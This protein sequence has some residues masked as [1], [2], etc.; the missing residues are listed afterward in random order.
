MREVEMK[1]RAAVPERISGIFSSRLGKAHPVHKADHYFRRPGESIQALRMRTNGGR[2][3]FT[4]KRTVSINGRE[5]NAEYEFHGLPGDEEAA[6][7]F[8]HALGYE[9]FFVKKKDGWEWNDGDAHIELLSV[10][11][12]GWFLEIEVLLPFDSSVED[13]EAARRHIEALMNEAG[14]GESD[15]ETR[16]YREMITGRK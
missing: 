13:G 8:F 4:T 10:N 14:I 5:D 16:S 7:A 11:D 9:D 12:L 6:A 2:L 15:I 1:A 3:E